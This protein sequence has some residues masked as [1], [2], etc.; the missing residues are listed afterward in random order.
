MSKTVKQ[1]MDTNS[2]SCKDRHYAADARS[3]MLAQLDLYAAY[4]RMTPEEQMD[5]FSPQTRLSEFSGCLCDHT[6]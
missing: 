2:R 6:G 4:C 5:M 1:F 3:R